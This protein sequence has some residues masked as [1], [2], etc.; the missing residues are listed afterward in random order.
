[1]NP[2]YLLSGIIFLPALGALILAFLDSRAV[3]HIRAIA[4]GFT[5]A[6]FVLTLMLWGQFDPKIAGMQMVV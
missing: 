2:D 6:T 4:L 3:S 1:M 5:V